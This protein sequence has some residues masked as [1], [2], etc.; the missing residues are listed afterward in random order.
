MDV[1]IILK[2]LAVVAVGV[3]MYAIWAKRFAWTLE[4]GITHG[5]EVLIYQSKHVSVQSCR[6]RVVYLMANYGQ[7]F[8]GAHAIAPDGTRTE[9]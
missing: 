3:L 7:T 1:T 2:V 9:L 4:F 6:N 8:S 5:D